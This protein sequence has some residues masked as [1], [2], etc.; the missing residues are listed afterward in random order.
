MNDYRNPYENN[1]QQDLNSGTF[2]NGSGYYSSSG[3]YYGSPTPKKPKKSGGSAKVVIASLLAAVIGAVGG[4]VCTA[5]LLNKPAAAQSS[6]STSKLNAS[7]VNIS[8]DESV[9]SIAQ[10]VAEKCTASVVGIRTTASSQNFFFGETESDGGSGSG[11]V[12]SE[13]GYIITNYHVISAA[14]ESTGKSKIDVYFGSVDTEPYEA[15]VIGYSI[16]SDLAVIKVN[17]TGLTPVELG[18]SDDLKVGQYAVTIGAPGG[19]EFMGS[20]TYGIISGLDRVVSSDSDVKL[21]QTDA[22]INPG[23]SGG[24]L[25][26]TN[27]RLIGINSSKIVSTEYEGMGFSIPVNTVIEKCRSII[28]R[29]NDPE[30]YVGITLS[31]KYTESVLK[32]YGYPA[33]AVVQSVD[34]NSPAKSA[35]ISR[36]DIITAF[37]STE[38]TSYSRLE[39]LIRESKPGDKVK[40]TLYRSGKSYTVELTIGSNNSNK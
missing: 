11:V 10:A 15:T 34:D 3:G 12:Y 39:E 5:T 1:G 37:G 30:S 2:G 6:G 24:A 20:V 18:N 38:V 26:D 17:A 19:L 16:S 22:A 31:K 9:G 13:D 29:Q 4:G 8:V 25:L 21:I 32:Y 27:G 7:S 28:E 40:V 35:G 36:G 23:N 14:V 33:G